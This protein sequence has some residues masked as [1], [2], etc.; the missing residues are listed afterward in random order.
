MK[1]VDLPIEFFGDL[2]NGLKA[3]IFGLSAVINLAIE[4]LEIISI[5]LSLLIKQHLEDVNDL[6][7]FFFDNLGRH[8]FA[9][10][11]FDFEFKPFGHTV[12]ME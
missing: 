10:C 12:E 2:V 11:T 3:S 8:F 9:V 5:V 7:T 6:L 1:D 4:V